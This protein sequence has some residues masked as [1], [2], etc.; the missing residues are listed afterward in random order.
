MR[1]SFQAVRRSLAFTSSF[2]RRYPASQSDREMPVY[3]GP[4][5]GEV[6]CTNDKESAVPP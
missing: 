5:W 1:M 4:V 2:T 6:A 3:E